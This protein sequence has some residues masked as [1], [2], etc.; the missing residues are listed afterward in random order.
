LAPKILVLA[1]RDPAQQLCGQEPQVSF[2]LNGEIGGDVMGREHA[3]H[4]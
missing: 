1:M 2:A 3:Q 4:R